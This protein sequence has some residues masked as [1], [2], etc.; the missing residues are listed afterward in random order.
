[1]I[2]LERMWV[3]QPSTL[4]AHHNLHGTRVLA[5]QAYRG[6]RPVTQVF[7]LDGPIHSMEI[8]NLALSAGWPEGQPGNAMDAFKRISIS[9]SDEPENIAV[10][11][12]VSYG[13]Q[14]REAAIQTKT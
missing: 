11:P 2:E 4:Q 7:F 10:L 1:M 9:A 5:A 13:A 12:T 14:L 6:E 3:N 8:D